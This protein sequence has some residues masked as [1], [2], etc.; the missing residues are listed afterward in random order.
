M[1]MTLE[2]FVQYANEP[3]GELSAEA[4]YSNVRER[5]VDILNAVRLLMEC[6]GL[7]LRQAVAIKDDIEPKLDKDD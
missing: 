7:D 1:R 3:K 5:G 4:Y 6:Y 2:E